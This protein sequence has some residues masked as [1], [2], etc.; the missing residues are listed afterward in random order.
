MEDDEEE[1]QETGC[2]TNEEFNAALGG[3]PLGSDKAKKHLLDKRAEMSLW[4]KE[5]A[6]Q[7]EQEGSE[8]P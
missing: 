8:M 1:K 2:I 6:E 5:I 3:F 7:A 4:K